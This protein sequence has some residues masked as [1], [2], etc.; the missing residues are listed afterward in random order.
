L[1]K[2]IAIRIAILFP[3]SIAIAIAIFLARIANSSGYYDI[4]KFTGKRLQ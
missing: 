1:R 4:T 2:S 3:S